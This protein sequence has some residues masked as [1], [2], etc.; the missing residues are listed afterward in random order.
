MD[1]LIYQWSILVQ[2][3]KAF[4]DTHTEEVIEHNGG[5]SQE[6]TKE[7]MQ[8]SQ[9][10]KMQTPTLW[11]SHI[12]AALM[13]W[14]QAVKHQMVDIKRSP[15]PGQGAG[16]ESCSWLPISDQS[17]RLAAST[18]LQKPARHKKQQQMWRP[19]RERPLRSYSRCLTRL[20]MTTQI[21]SLKHCQP[22]TV[23]WVLSIWLSVCIHSC[24][25]CIQINIYIFFTIDYDQ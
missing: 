15:N 11:G 10:V 12:S 7:E 13:P 21:L 4:V 8:D 23:G 19:R 9:E 25:S 22:Q 18:W 20:R 2:K 1:R 17:A 24:I 14:A 3:D 5:R 16:A 6:L